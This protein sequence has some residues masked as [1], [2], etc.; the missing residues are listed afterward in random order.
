VKS[1]GPSI[2]A[3]DMAL[4]LVF[5]HFIRH[6]DLSH[7]SWLLDAYD[8]S[9]KYVCSICNLCGWYKSDI[10]LFCAYLFWMYTVIFLSV[11][12]LS[13]RSTKVMPNANLVLSAENFFRLDPI[14]YLGGVLKCHVTLATLNYV[15]LQAIFLI[16]LLVWSLQ[17]F[18]VFH[19]KISTFF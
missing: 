1:Q 9:W 3:P 16:K 13:S 2:V 6:I 15:K 7:Y 10:P 17:S 19:L 8:V 18:S 11:F 12:C 5:C 4:T 14:A